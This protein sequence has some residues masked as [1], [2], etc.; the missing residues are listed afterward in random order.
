MHKAIKYAIQLNKEQTKLANK[1]FGCT[2]FVY[3]KVLDMQQE[4]HANGEKRFSKNRANEWCNHVLK[5]EYPWLKEVDK[6]SLT[7]AAWNMDD[8]YQRFFSKQGG[9]PKHKR[10]HASRD[11]WTTNITGK[12]IEIGNGEVKL[13]KLGW[14]KAKIHRQPKQNW[15]IK[16]ATVSRDKT[17][18]YFVSILFY[19]EEIISPVVVRKAVGLDYKSDG[20]YADSEGNIKGSPKYF[21][22]SAK[23]LAKEQ[24]KLARKVGNN[25]GEEKSKNWL[26]QRAKVD[27]I[28]KKI[29]NQ[30][31]D[32]AHQVSCQIANEWDLVGV[33]DLNLTSISNKGFGNGKATLD[34]G[35][36]MFRIFL[37]YKLRDR[38]KYLVK[39]DKWFPSSQI[40]SDCGFQNKAVKDVTVKKWTCPNCG[41][42]HDRD[43]NAAVNIRNEALRQVGLGRPELMPAEVV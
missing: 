4:R 24:R 17:G 40:C 1:T 22:K 43:I 41:E 32:F 15:I 7:N 27:K 16:S 36:G 19:Y 2:R 37:E 39:V 5:E 18:K 10:K 8:A 23:K 31:M 33:E 38:G 21:R 11:S 42:A 13:P 26:K 28:Y 25:K 9:F 20:F 3:N 30:R 34:N 35:F 6:F 14:V 12:N 29:R